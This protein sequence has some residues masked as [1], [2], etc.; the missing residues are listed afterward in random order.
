[1]TYLAAIIGLSFLRLRRHMRM[2]FWSG[3]AGLVGLH[4]VMKA[5]VWALVARTK[6]VTGSTGYHRFALIDSAIKNFREWW[7]V[8]TY[9]TGHW[10]WGFRT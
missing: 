6:I 2:V 10:G 9:L 7:L 1:M 8:G 3:V 5:P 4:M